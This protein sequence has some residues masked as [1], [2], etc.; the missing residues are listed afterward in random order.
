M[1]PAS[2]CDT[3]VLPHRM[4]WELAESKSII[5][6]RK[7]PIELLE[8]C[9]AGRHK[10]PTAGCRNSQSVKATSVVRIRGYDK[11]K[12]VNGPQGHLLDYAQGPSRGASIIW[13]GDDSRGH[14]AAETISPRPYLTFQ[15]LSGIQQP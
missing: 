13:R 6:S 8:R 1:L 10:D 15:T 11:G 9:R 2:N 5:D 3:I 7:K 14:D 12:Q 4:R